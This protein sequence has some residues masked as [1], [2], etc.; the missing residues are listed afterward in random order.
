MNKTKRDLE[1]EVKNKESTITSFYSILC[2]SLSNND[3]GT[4]PIPTLFFLQ[5]KINLY[6]CKKTYKFLLLTYTEF[7]F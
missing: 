6:I 2:L 7:N 1:I 3:L 4:I 5:I